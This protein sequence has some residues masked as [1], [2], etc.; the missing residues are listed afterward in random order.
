MLEQNLPRRRM[1]PVEEKASHGPVKTFFSDSLNEGQQDAVK[2][3][4]E[5]M[6]S[7]TVFVCHV[8]PRLYLPF[9]FCDKP[10]ICVAS[11]KLLNAC[12]Y[13]ENLILR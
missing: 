9:F 3:A 4:I 12:V 2:F 10:Q 11:L 6:Y 8:R 5:G 13:F 7:D 1:H